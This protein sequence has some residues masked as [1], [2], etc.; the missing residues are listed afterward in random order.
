MRSATGLFIPILAVLFGC[1][2]N[3]Q[4]IQS[5]SSNLKPLAIM[6]GQYVA[7]HQGKPP[8]SESEFK[9]FIKSDGAAF[10]KSFH[11][12]DPESI[13]TSSRDKKPYVI[14]YGPVTGP[15]GPG[16]QP[17]VAYEQEGEGGKRYVATPV[18]AVEAVDEARFRQLVPAGK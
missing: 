14:L 12:D 9:E 8:A 3:Q 10:L 11:V 17:V 4:K 7:K 16:G 6:Y 18:G 5:E 2:P 1:G 13:F 15:P